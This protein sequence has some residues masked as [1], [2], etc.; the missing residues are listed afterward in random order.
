L[1]F[2]QGAQYKISK[3]KLSISMIVVV[4][5]DSGRRAAPMPAYNFHFRRSLSIAW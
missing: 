2:E 3:T 4:D 5:R 1:L